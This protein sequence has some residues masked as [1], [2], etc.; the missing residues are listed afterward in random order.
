M[1]LYQ[2]W[3]QRL[4]KWQTRLCMAAGQSHCMWA[5]KVA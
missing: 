4:L 3:G 2:L 5:W 1:Y